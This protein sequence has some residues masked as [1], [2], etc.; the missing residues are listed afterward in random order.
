MQIHIVDVLRKTGFVMAALFL[1]I[2]VSRLS[3]S[4]AYDHASRNVSAADSLTSN[5][6]TNEVDPATR[7]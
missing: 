7:M 2:L 5:S 4:I 3:D 6:K 1:I